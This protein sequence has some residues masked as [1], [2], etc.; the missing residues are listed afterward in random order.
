MPGF[1]IGQGG[2]GDAP[3]STIESRR[4]HRWV[5]DTLGDNGPTNTRVYLQNAQR[6]HV[7]AEEVVMHHNQEQVYFAGK[8]RW[9]PITLV[10]YDVSGGGDDA[11]EE[12]W[13]WFNSVVEV[14]QANVA[15]PSEYKKTARLQMLKGDGDPNETW[16][17][18]NSWP[19]DVNWNDLDYTN[20]EIQTID[21]QM[22]YDRAIRE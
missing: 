11:S 1:Q 16:K 17:L 8:H 12:V 13:D 6:P 20:T 4:K 22:K 10:F 21:V 5:F 2:Q 7:V 19:I 14:P 18:F 9:E 15:V 3:N